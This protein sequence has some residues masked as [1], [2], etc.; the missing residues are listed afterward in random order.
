MNISQATCF[1]ILCLTPA[2]LLSQ[3]I[4]KTT[5]ED[6]KVIFS[7]TPQKNSEKISAELTNIQQPIEA[8]KTIKRTNRVKATGY[9][10]RLSSPTEGQF[11]SPS[12]RSLTIQISLSQP[13][14][15]HH[16]IEFLVDGKRVASPS[17]STSIST[18][19]GIKMRGR[20]QVSARVIEM[21]GKI[22]A[23][24]SPVSIQVFRPN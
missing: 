4:Y 3:E 20:H 13:L 19:M 14:Q 8:T 10:A 7:D 16:L 11:L 21:N 9:E 22:V 6:G 2:S 24:T 1:A 23:S 15:N 18:P 17:T 12:Q 5:N